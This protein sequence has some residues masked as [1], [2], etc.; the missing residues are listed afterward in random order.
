LRPHFLAI[1]TPEQG[2][3]TV[4]S[5]KANGSDFIKAYSSLSRDTFFAIAGEASKVKIPFAGHVPFSVPALEAS[6][7]M[8][9]TERLHGI[10]LSCCAREDNLRSEML[11]G[12]ANLPGDDRL[13]LEM[14]EAAAS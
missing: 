14:H 11:K 5:L 9:S 1:T 8:K 7:G 12:G 4:D 6:D 13:R 3:A 2:R 10:V